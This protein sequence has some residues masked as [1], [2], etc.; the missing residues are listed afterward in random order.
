MTKCRSLLIAALIAA[1]AAP[2]LTMAQTMPSTPQNDFK[3]ADAAMTRE[4]EST[5]RFMKR[6]DSGNRAKK[7]RLAADLLASQRAWLSF[8]DAQCTI[9][10]A[11]FAGGS[12]AATAQL[13]CLAA[14]TRARGRQLASLRW[15]H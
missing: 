2:S 14:L 8:R 6:R 15:R 3:A 12:L 5:Q 9:E 10:A 11:E 4:W 13:T 1:C 7:G